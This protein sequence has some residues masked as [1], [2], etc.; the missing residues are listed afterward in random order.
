MKRI[1]VMFMS[2]GLIAGSTTAADAKKPARVE[3]IIES[4]YEAYPTPVTGCNEPLGYWACLI[5]QTRANEAFF[6]AKVTD[7][8][9]QPVY[10]VVGGAGRNVSFC[11]ETKEPVAIKPGSELSFHLGV[12]WHINPPP[13]AA[14]CPTSRVKT[15]GTIRVVLSNAR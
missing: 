15:T 13:V 8:H 7:A 5:V 9:G 10:V 12:T 2:L 1:L 3:R 14:D 6:T 11:G 4:R